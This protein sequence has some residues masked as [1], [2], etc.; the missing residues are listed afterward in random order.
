MMKRVCAVLLLGCLLCLALA[1][2]GKTDLD[3][4]QEYMDNHPL[5]E[6]KLYTVSFCLV[7]DAAIPDDLLKGMQLQFSQYT[8][9]NY[10][11]KVEF[12]NVTKG[13][14]KDWLAAE[15]ARVEEARNAGE[16]AASAASAG[17]I[18]SDIRD[19]YPE[20]AADQ[21]D[22]IYIADYN[23]LRDLVNAGRL[24]DMAAELTGKDYRL[25]KKYM[26]TQF[27]DA[28]TLNGRIYALP[29]CRV[30]ANYKYLRVNAEKAKAYNFEFDYNLSD[31]ESTEILRAGLEANGEN[32][33]DFVQQN[34]VGDYAKRAELAEDGAWWVYG[35]EKEQRPKINQ[36]AL[37]NG[38]LAVTS[39][40]CVDKGEDPDKTEDDFCPAVKILYEITVNPALHT[41][42]QYGV[43]D[44]TYSLK[45]VTDG[46]RKVTVVNKLTDT[47]NVDPK[48]TGNIF[49]L[50]P[51]EE[52]FEKGMQE[53][54]RRQND[55]TIITK[56]IFDVN[57]TVAQPKDAGCVAL[58][59]RPFSKDNEKVTLKATPA[60]GYRL[61][62]WSVSEDGNDDPYEYTETEQ[63]IW[64]FSYDGFTTSI[65]AT[66]EKTA[67]E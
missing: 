28:A 3:K 63:E 49:S 50:Y 29:S 15:F 23:M 53:N 65:K 48:Y 42:L 4:S 66:F 10:N 12:T 18:G 19:V 59:S 64:F 38:A 32:P 41:I 46:D 37:F 43:Q 17:S 6:K 45:T 62:N 30:M 27:F 7:S 31:Y 51:T 16:G 60:E 55:D 8:E 58:P 44:L 25:I 61:V 34:I 47:Y 9:T 33:A 21:F 52:E 20:I 57:V 13:E 36:S 26:T 5:A 56:D 22:L 67:E 35:S 14:Y 1:G 11:I 40:A 2:C 54:N 39:F 24:R